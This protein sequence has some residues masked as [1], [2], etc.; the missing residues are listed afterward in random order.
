MALIK[1]MRILKTRV[2]YHRIEKLEI[3][4]GLRVGVYVLSYADEE[5]RQAELDG[6]EVNSVSSY[7]CTD[8]PEGPSTIEE[9]YEWLKTERPE[10]EGAEDA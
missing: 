3:E 5:E 8:T 2:E 10:F 7:Y 1:R 6:E 4:T 9:A